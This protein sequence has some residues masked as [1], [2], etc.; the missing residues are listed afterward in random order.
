MTCLLFVYDAGVGVRVGPICS[1][2]VHQAATLDRCVSPEGDIDGPCQ[3]GQPVEG[4]QGAL[5]AVALRDAG[6]WAGNIH[7]EEEPAEVTT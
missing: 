2:G 1:E 7:G 5:P 3:Q 6:R 4:P